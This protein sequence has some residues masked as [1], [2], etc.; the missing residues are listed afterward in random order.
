[1]ELDASQ[2]WNNFFIQNDVACHV[3]PYLIKAN[4]LIFA[5]DQ[6]IYF[7]SDLRHDDAMYYPECAVFCSSTLWAV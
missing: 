2:M 6:Y 4:F 7:A 3:D 5:L 1:M